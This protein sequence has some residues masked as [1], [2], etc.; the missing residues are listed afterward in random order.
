MTGAPF[1]PPINHAATDPATGFYSVTL[2]ADR[3]YSL[4]VSSPLHAPQVIGIAA[5]NADRTENF[6]LIPTTD[7]TGGIIGWVR[8]LTTQQ[9]V[10]SATVTITPG[11][12][13]KTDQSRLLRGV[14][15]D[16]R[17]LHHQGRGVSLRTAD[18]TRMSA[19]RPALSPSAPLIWLPRIWN[20]VRL[21]WTA[22]SSL[23]RSPGRRRRWC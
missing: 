13:V 15:S 3:A 1:D 20:T 17:L 16:A 7:V 4:T 12:E 5:L 23:A 18:R 6:A 19:C 22:R 2:A 8:N 9:P 14:E 10:V 11:L 21:V